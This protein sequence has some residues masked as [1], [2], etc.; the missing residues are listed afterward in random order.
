MEG[1][2]HL[3]PLD[4][5]IPPLYNAFIFGFP[6][7]TNEHDRAVSILEGGWSKTLDKLPSLASE[8]EFDQSEGERPGTLKL[9][10]FD[11]RQHGT[12]VVNDLTDPGTAWKETY[13][14]LRAQGMPS[15]KLDG[16]VLAPLVSGIGTTSKVATIQINLIPG[17]CLLS[18]CTS[19]SFIDASGCAT[20]LKLWAEHCRQLQASPAASGLNSSDP[21][22]C[23]R[24]FPLLDTKGSHEAYQ[25][26]K[27][28]SNVWHLLGLHATENLGP[29]ARALKKREFCH[30]PAAPPLSKD[31]DNTSCIFAVTRDALKKL[32]EEASPER[33]EWVSSGD[34]LVAVLWRSIMLARFPSGASDAAQ[35]TK[36]SI[37]TVAVD[38]RKIL[39]TP[40]PSS[41][42]GNVVFCCMTRLTLGDLFSPK[43]SLADL[44]LRIRRNVEATKQ[45]GLLE[46]A[47]CLAASIPD[48]SS[49]QF[50]FHDFLGADLITT[51]WVELSFYDVD[52]GPIFGNDGRVEFFRM[53]RGQFGGICSLQ[54]RQKNGTVDVSICLH[55]EQ[56]KR[57]RKNE[58][59]AQYAQF[60]SE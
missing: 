48:V 13:E 11:H 42:I 44:A 59:F 27:D 31:L 28:S 52:F 46:E 32:K 37:V 53:P 40:L 43:T 10:F 7:P 8:I 39:R 24:T 3:S 41:Y 23:S 16:R 54:P 57:L 49:L 60:V 38:G 5:I 12:L 45:Q 22:A 9:R 6:C 25:T 2:D 1:Q 56:M 36:E 50:A 58:L 17:G 55:A 14:E 15:S 20:V 30:F 34:A 29:D 26:L 51:S 21:L 35:N 18:L 4:E 33:P 47:I 19:H